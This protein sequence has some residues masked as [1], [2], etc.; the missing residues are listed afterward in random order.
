[1]T[2]FLMVALAV[3]FV[4]LVVQTIRIEELR[5]ELF[6]LRREADRQCAAAD[7]HSRKLK[8]VLNQLES[9]VKS[10]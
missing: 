5:S 9:I 3:V 8:T 1:M 6:S 10:N 7:H 2:V 4:L